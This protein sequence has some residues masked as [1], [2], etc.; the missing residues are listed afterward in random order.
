[1]K[2]VMNSKFNRLM[3]TPEEPRHK[4]ALKLIA[5]AIVALVIGFGIGYAALMPQVNSLRLQVNLLNDALGT[6]YQDYV[7]SHTHN[8]SDYDSLKAER[9]LLKDIADLEKYQVLVDRQTMTQP[10]STSTS[11]SLS[12]AYAGYL[13]VEIIT[14]TAD[15]IFVEVFYISHG[16]NFYQEIRVGTSGTAVFPILPSNDIRIRIGNTN[17]VNSATEMVTVT[18]HY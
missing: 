5:V 18:Y 8:D 17:L 9:N 4:S 12:A 13:E 2:E 7:L 10:A 11:W 15:N 16:V 3:Q 6:T 14:S 1:M